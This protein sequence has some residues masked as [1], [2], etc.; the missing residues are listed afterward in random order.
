MIRTRRW[1]RRSASCN[2]L[3][4]G[5][6]P[7]FERLEDRAL[8]SGA[9]GLDPSALT[10]SVGNLQIETAPSDLPT[11]SI[12]PTTLGTGTFENNDSS[13]GAEIHGATWNDLDGNGAWDSGEPVLANRQIYIDQN[14]NDQWDPG[15]PSTTTDSSGNYAFTGLAA[16]TY[17]VAEVQR[18]GWTQTC[19]T[20][21]VTRPA[22][23]SST[24]GTPE[25]LTS[26]QIVPEVA[27]SGPQASADTSNSVVTVFSASAVMLNEV[28]TSTWTYGCSATSAGMLFGYY[29][30]H[31]Y[32]NMYTGPANG[33]VAPLQNLGQGAN[34]SSPIAGACSI[35]ATQNGFDGRTTPGHVDDYWK[36]YGKPGPDPWE[37]NQTEHDWS[38]CTADFMGTN[39]WKWDYDLNSQKESNTD[40]ATSF[41]NYTTS[42]SRLND[43]IPPAENGLPQTE[44]CHGMRLFAESRGYTVLENYSQKIDTKFADGFS[45]ANFETEI[46]T[47]H[48]VLIQ[49]EGH[50]MVGVGYD[51]ANNTV[52]LHDTWDNMVH[53]MTWGGSYSGMEQYGVTVIHLAAAPPLGSYS[54]VLATG[55][56]VTGKNFG[57]RDSAPLASTQNVSLKEGN[58]PTTRFTFTVTLPARSTQAITV[59][60]ATQAGTAT[61]GIDYTDT[62]GTLTFKAG[63][64]KKT[65]TVA[66]TG[67]K[68]FE[69]TETFRLRLS[70]S[71]TSEVFAQATGTIRNDD[72]APAVSIV[73]V[74]PQEE[75]SSA[76]TD[77]TF[78][79][80]LSSVSGLPVTVH[81]STA[82]GSAKSDTDYA[83][84]SRD[85]TIPAGVTVGTFT[86]QIGGDTM[87]EANETFTATLSSPQGAS[88]AKGKSKATATIQ[89]DDDPPMVYIDDANLA[90][91]AT[92]LTARFLVHLSAVSGIAAKVN[93]ST[94][95]GTAKAGKDFKKMSGTLTIAAGLDSYTISVPILGN[96]A[97]SAGETFYVKI[98]S[99]KQATPVDSQ[100]QGTCTI[101]PLQNLAS[102]MDALAV[103]QKPASRTNAQQHGPAVDEAIRLL[104]LAGCP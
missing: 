38:A 48:P 68:T 13:S 16:G 71:A 35:I 23:G 42:G 57:N 61:A 52:Y 77:F 2:S 53:S 58:S 101:H 12:S 85:L 102:L 70:D 51:A 62:S 80:K 94:A 82:D 41:F 47:G 60:Y 14:S 18:I 20:G 64:T 84:N 91:G 11:V 96:P 87:H 19:P 99:P 72:K 76:T 90:P 39:Q 33:G 79:V 95:A 44:G 69:S 98:S 50:T 104:M 75:G 100:T 83:A 24:V 88:L 36:G 25:D 17:T 34:P 55:Q 7:R 65:I 45:F 54:V 22:S 5:R 66:V 31:G 9:N 27:D 103:F 43:Y 46:D 73:G 26:G 89:D 40:G 63:E 78:N 92:N 28:P 81:C 32:P 59:N 15:E 3:T 49:V 67:D 29:D 1:G 37:G 56:V 8:L 86:V 4:T 30:R 74:K 10:L 97:A 93:Y 6:Q 21:T